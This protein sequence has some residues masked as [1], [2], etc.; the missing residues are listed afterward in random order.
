MG[1][2]RWGYLLVR[3]YYTVDLRGVYYFVFKGSN[4]Q[5]NEIETD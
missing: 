3:Q 2:L 5:I 1:K 4:R